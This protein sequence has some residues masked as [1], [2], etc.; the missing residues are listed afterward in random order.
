MT[1]QI[2]DGQARFQCSLVEFY[3]QPLLVVQAARYGIMIP[4]TSD[5]DDDAEPAYAYVNALSD[6]SVRWIA[7]C[8]DCDMSAE[9]VWLATP[10]MFCMSCC[11]RALGGRWRRVEVPSDR[12]EIERLLLARTDPRTRSWTPDE[13]VDDLLAENVTLSGGGG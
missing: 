10:L 3:R 4:P 13:T 9:Y 5:V 11:N 2:L 1:A 8:P 7:N 12:A 6:G